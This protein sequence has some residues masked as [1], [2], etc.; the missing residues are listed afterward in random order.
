[1]RRP[2]DLAFAVE[3]EGRRVHRAVRADRQPFDRDRHV[4]GQVG[5]DGENIGVPAILSAGG[6]DGADQQQNQLCFTDQYPSHDAIPQS[7]W[8]IRAEVVVEIP[9]SV[10]PCV[11][12]RAGVKHRFSS[13][14]S[15]TLVPPFPRSRMRSRPVLAMPSRNADHR[16]ALM[17]VAGLEI[18]RCDAGWRN[19]HFLKLAT[20]EGIV[21]WSEFDEGFG[22]PGVGALIERLAGRV[23]GQPVFDHERI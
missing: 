18:L 8:L 12:S 3:P 2:Q 1:M 10:E 5:H 7:L 13:L 17:R 22:S 19:Y 15:P 6:H 4:A 9:Y 20:D 21:G 11:F 16:R 14:L 23:V